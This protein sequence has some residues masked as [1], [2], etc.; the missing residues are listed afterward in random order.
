MAAAGEGSDLKGGTE[1]QRPHRVP[2]IYDV[3][4]PQGAG[5]LLLALSFPIDKQRVAGTLQQ[6][7]SGQA[8]YHRRS[9]KPLQTNRQ[10]EGLHSMN[11][12]ELGLLTGTCAVLQRVKRVMLPPLASFALCVPNF[13]SA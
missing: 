3:L 2:Q 11:Q 9:A 4:L 1:P 12:S 10:I 8:S 5:G 6:S 13:S 7:L